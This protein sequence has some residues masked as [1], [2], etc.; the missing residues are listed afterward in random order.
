MTAALVPLR[1]YVTSIK[2]G[3]HGTHERV[4]E[5]IPL[6]SA[7]NIQDGS[8]VI[9]LEDSHITPDEFSEIHRSG[10]LAPGDVLLTIVGTIG[11]TAIYDGELQIAFQRSVASLRPAANCCA[12]YLFY[13][14][15]SSLIQ[16]QLA[17]S[18]HQ[19]AQSGIYLGDLANVMLPLLPLAT[20]QAIVDYLDCETARI[21]AL[22][23]A[24]RRMV[25]LLE[26]HLR[27][28]RV[29]LVVDRDNPVRQDGPS[30]L[31]S[32]PCAWRLARLKFVA[33]MESGHTPNKQVDTYWVNCTIPWITLNDV[34]NLEDAWRFFN[35]KNAVNELGLQNSSARVLPADAVVMSRDATIGRSAILGR[36]MAVS[37]HFVAW[38]CGTKLLPEYL[39]NVIR[40]PMQHHFGS[41]TAG[42]TIATIGMP[43]LNQLVVPLPPIAEQV[44]IVKAIA[45][46]EDIAR[47][48]IS[49][50]NRQIALLRERRQALIT[51]AVMSEL[52]IAEAL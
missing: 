37:Q 25:E 34:S 27:T 13:C 51:A 47:R 48:T 50:V 43:D 6:L 11:R 35:P 41:L 45:D 38:I 31:G 7:K 32:I 17:A 20:Q 9:G 22:I 12:R 18:A 42:A 10:Y 44:Q 2:D 4:D 23:A 28:E 40:G 36:P 8:I 24:K 15:S 52:D 39:L 29:A 26:E 49:V 1:R 30:W 14:L 3:T 33:R 16:E 21:D 5:G 46:V 19:A